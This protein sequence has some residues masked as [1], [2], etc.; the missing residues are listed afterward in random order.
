MYIKTLFMFSVS[1]PSQVQIQK[2]SL[3][4]L[5]T[6]NLGWI[7]RNWAAREWIKKAESQIEFNLA[8]NIK[9]NE[10]SFYMH[11]R[12]RR[13]ARKNVGCVLQENGNL[14]IQEKAAALYGIFAS[15]VIGKRS[16]YT[17]LFTQSKHKDCV[18]MGEIFLNL[19]D[20]SS[21]LH[22]NFL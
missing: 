3:Q 11:V 8:R 5:R 22:T 17:I 19:E 9:D 14:V 15:V 4:Q 10:M 21:L 6:G 1:F 16:I 13:K 20:S 7:E 12:D 2:R 18:I